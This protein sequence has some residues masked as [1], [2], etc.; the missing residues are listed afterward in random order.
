VLSPFKT[1]T[2]HICRVNIL[3]GSVHIVK[4]NIGA[5]VVAGMNKDTEKSRRSQLRCFSNNNNNNK[6]KDTISFMQ[7]IC[8]Y[9]PETDK[10]C[11]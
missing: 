1:D 4:K 5:L 2:F 3:D 6:G 11:P 10:P 7:G 9:I 8:T